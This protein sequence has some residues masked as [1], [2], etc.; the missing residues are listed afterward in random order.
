MRERKKVTMT[1][2][3]KSES[4]M[5]KRQSW[6]V[7]TMFGVLVFGFTAA[8]LIKPDASFSETENRTL[9]QMPEVRLDTV[10]S[11]EF[12]SD[13]EKYL[14]DQ[15][16]LRDGWIGLKTNVE[17]ALLKTE[18]KDIYFADDGYL[19]EKHTGSFTG[20]TAQRNIQ[21]LSQFMEHYLEKFGAEH[22]T[23]MVV[24]NAVDILEEKLPAFASP[25]DQEEYLGRVAEAMPE[26]V[27]FDAGEILE[28]HDEEELYYRT[29]HHWKTQ[30][31]FYVYQ[32]WAEAKGL[33]VPS[34]EDYQVETV[35]D[36]FEGTIQSKL[37][38]HTG[39]DTIQLFLP[40]EDIFYTVQKNEEEETSYS[41]YDYSALDTKDKYAVYFGGNQAL[42]RMK[43]RTESDRKILVIKDSY[44]HCF[45]PFMLKEFREIDVL[46]IRYY[47]QKVSELIEEGGYTD[48]LFLYNAS[49]FAEDTSIT[50]LLN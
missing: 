34:P 9:A 13:Y 39:G 10:F 3:L 46:D 37:G 42:T 35:T 25:Y 48:L 18:S 17:R 36:S 50:R 21:V 33:P 15:F 44:A 7:I 45:I 8:T 22:M 38:I 20:D 28:A 6:N 14:T 4:R 26:G 27:W 29:D 2:E 43:V 31:A 5:T 49:G 32:K 47:N 24:P 19:I 1:E 30:A 16:V 12:E 11:G 23:A 40:K 41:L